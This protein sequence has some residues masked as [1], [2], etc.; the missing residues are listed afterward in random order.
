MC[1]RFALV[2]VCL[3]FLP[4][5]YEP[6]EGNAK[7]NE[8]M[9]INPR[10]SNA[11]LDVSGK[12]LMPARVVKPWHGYYQAAGLRIVVDKDSVA[13]WKRAAKRPEWST[14]TVDA[15]HAQRL[16]GKRLNG[17]RHPAQG[18]N[19]IRAKMYAKQHAALVEVQITA[20]KAE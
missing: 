6:R 2:I 18:T 1:F 10:L 8:K 12:S 14:K 7:K 9:V 16:Y 4:G 20:G 3:A 17:S 15:A 19:Q 13:G 11:V 5:C